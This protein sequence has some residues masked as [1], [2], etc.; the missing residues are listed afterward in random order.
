MLGR[1]LLLGLRRGNFPSLASVSLTVRGKCGL[2]DP[3]GR[4]FGCQMSSSVWA[5][6]P[7]LP[8]TSLWDFSTSVCCP[9][10]CALPTISMHTS[11]ITWSAREVQAAQQQSWSPQPCSHLG[12][13]LP[14]PTPNSPPP[15][16]PAHLKQSLTSLGFNPPGLDSTSVTCQSLSS[17]P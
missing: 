16:T 11:W 14:A 8:W 4:G 10:H 2:H 5:P 6:A 7:R 9:D 3:G 1:F 12:Q 17:E 13:R 15:P